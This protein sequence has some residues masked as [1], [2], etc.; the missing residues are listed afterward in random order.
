MRLPKS[1]AFSLSAGVDLAVLRGVDQAA[2]RPRLGAG[3][4]GPAGG[5][6]GAGAGRG[7]SRCRQQPRA[8]GGAWA[9]AGGAAEV[10]EGR[11]APG[12]GHPVGAGAISMALLPLQPLLEAAR[13]RG[14]AALAARVCDAGLGRADSPQGRLCSLSS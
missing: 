11:G 5:R 9:R 6:A 4:A 3:R 10:S 12:G 13:G 1:S 2:L 7:R 8:G 14:N